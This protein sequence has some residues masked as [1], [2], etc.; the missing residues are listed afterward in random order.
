MKY[1][2]RNIYKAIQDQRDTALL[3]CSFKVSKHPIPTAMDQLRPAKYRLSKHTYLLA[4]LLDR[5]SKTPDTT[6]ENHPNQL[7]TAIQHIAS[8]TSEIT[9]PSKTPHTFSSLIG[10]H[11]LSLSRHK[12]APDTHRHDTS[13]SNSRRRGQ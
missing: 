10:H 13:K 1:Y 6:A 8:K 7:D 2:R 3:H 4:I 9:P 5:N 12:K 11:A